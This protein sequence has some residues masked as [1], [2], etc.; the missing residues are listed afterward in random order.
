MLKE[1]TRPMDLLGVWVVILLLN[2]VF[3]TSYSAVCEW[4]WKIDAAQGLDPSSL[5]AG[6]RKL[7]VLR[8][9]HDMEHCQMACCAE[10]ACQLAMIGTPADGTPECQLVSCMQDGRDVCLLQPSTQ[11]KV[12]RKKT[13]VETDRQNATELPSLSTDARAR[14][15]GNSTNFEKDQCRR[16]MKVGSCKAAF[17]RFY[18]DMYTQSCR[19]FIY[20]GCESNGNNFES[21]RECETACEGV[22]VPPT[23]DVPL[24]E[25]SEDEFAHLCGVAPAVGPCRAA[26]PR[27]YYNSDTHTCQ[28]FIYGGCRGNKNNYGSQENCKVACTVT[29]LPS[30]KKS[31]GKMIPMEPQD[32]KDHC[33]EGPEPGPCRAAFPRFF[34]QPST[35]SCLSFIYGGCRGNKNRYETL[36]DCMSKCDGRGHTGQDAQGT[37]GGRDRSPAFFLVGTLAVI[38]VLVLTGLIMITLHRNKVLRR[39]TTISDKEELLP[40]QGEHSSL[41]SL[42]VPESPRTGKV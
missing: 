33:L 3:P 9:V 34:Y 18:Y 38:S 7:S 25:I 24:P 31:K 36:D 11:F 41:E 30:P 28:S 10:T 40:D 21:V 8:D 12:Y 2:A 13:Q 14:S 4:D 19:K 16:L 17:P 1:M 42:S 35:G 29:V 26:L 22:K 15:E 32:S 39:S 20:G 37:V 5:D 27:W 23:S 6:A